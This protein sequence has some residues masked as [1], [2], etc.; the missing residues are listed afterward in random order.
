MAAMWRA[1]RLSMI[2]TSRSASG[3]PDRGRRRNRH[4]PH[5]GTSLFGGRGRPRDAVIGAL[6]IVM[7]PN[8]IGLRPSLPASFQT[9][10]TG[11]VLLIAAGVDALSRRRSVA[12]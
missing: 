2:G 4:E 12:H 9:V 7:I 3:T 6:V 1:A 5:R 10:I 8:G 11:A